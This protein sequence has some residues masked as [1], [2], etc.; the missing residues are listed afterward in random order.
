MAEWVRF[1]RAVKDFQAKDG[2][3]VDGM[4]G[5]Q[6]LD[7][8]RNAFQVLPQIN[9]LKAIGPVVFARAEQPTSPPTNQVQAYG[10]PAAIWNLYGGAI[11]EQAKAHGIPINVALSIFTVEAGGRAYDPTTGL[12]LIQF[13][14]H[15]F[16]NRSRTYYKPPRYG[17][18]AQEWADLEAAARTSLT[19]AF[20]STGAGLPQIMGFNAGLA[21]YS[22]AIE[23]FVAFQRSATEQ[24]KGFFNFLYFHTVEI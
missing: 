22:N 1:E 19:A 15:V 9:T 8:L 11:G 13:E 3:Q 12:I 20:E 2:L 23:M 4:L 10:L 18:Q 17:T 16:S 5:P 24:V 21:G 6:T 14:D 7:S